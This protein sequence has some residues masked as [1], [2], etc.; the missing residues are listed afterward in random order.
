MSIKESALAAVT[1]LSNSDFIR[2]VTS[3]GAS[4]KISLSNLPVAR[5]SASSL[6]SVQF[7]VSTGLT[8][9][10]AFEVYATHESSGDTYN[11][12]VTESNIQL[13]VRRSGSSSYSLLKT[14]S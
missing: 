9:A 10:R 6:S 7:S 8:P 3:G 1:S 4:R 12:V 14:W 2:V 13:Y 11:L 5:R